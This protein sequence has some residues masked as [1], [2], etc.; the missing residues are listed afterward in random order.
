MPPPPLPPPQHSRAPTDAQNEVIVMK[1]LEVCR[2][3]RGISELALAG[4]WWL[5]FNLISP[6]RPG[7]CAVATKAGLYE[8]GMQALH[9]SS[10]V[11]WVDWATPAG[12][13]R[14]TVGFYQH[15]YFSHGQALMWPWAVT[16]ACRSHGRR[17]SHD[18]RAASD[19]R[20]TWGERAANRARERHCRG[21]CLNAEGQSDD[22]HEIIPR[23]W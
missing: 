11:E 16:R 15:P 19:L 13:T 7:V 6:A 21:H 2:N 23:W 12:S 20:G 1:A 10:P 18:D 9:R 14:S 17:D 22:D 3:P 8:A 5:I 4:I